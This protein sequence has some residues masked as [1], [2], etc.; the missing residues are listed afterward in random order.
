MKQALPFILALLALHSVPLILS[1]SPSYAFFYFVQQWPGSACDAKMPCC[2][3]TTG[4]PAADF[5]IRGLWPGS[6]DG[7]SP[8]NCDPRNLFN[9]SQVKD[10]LPQLR[11]VWPSL[12]CPSSSGAYKWAREWETRG[13]CSKTVLNQHQYFQAAIKLKPKANILS[14]LTKAGIRPNG[15]FY[16]KYSIS[17]AI[18][19]SI[20]YEPYIECNVDKSGNSQL[21][22]VHVCVDTSAS[23]IIECPGMPQGGCGSKLKFPAF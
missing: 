22:Q 13:M 20:G 11:K 15:G 1:A 5:I 7:S 16:S 8:S 4:K 10:L 9:P 17:E 21:Y 23:K 12:S 3:P 14:I 6:L 19:T 2:Y 18:R